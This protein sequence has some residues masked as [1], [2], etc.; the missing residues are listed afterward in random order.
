MILTPE[1]LRHHLETYHLFQSDIMC[2]YDSNILCLP[3]DK[4]CAH[5]F[6]NHAKCLHSYVLKSDYHHHD[7]QFWFLI[8]QC[9]QW[10]GLGSFLYFSVMENCIFSVKRKQ[11]VCYE[12]KQTTSKRNRPILFPVSRKWWVLCQRKI[13]SSQSW[14][15]YQFSL[16][17]RIISLAWGNDQFPFQG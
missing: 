7:Q 3:W 11:Q 9:R 13:T 10:R 12:E 2:V 17:K 8:V 4:M 15:K 16:G 1:F 6:C 5:L 14:E